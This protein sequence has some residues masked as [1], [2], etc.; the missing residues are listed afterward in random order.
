MREFQITLRKFH[1]HLQKRR[2]KDHSLELKDPS[3]YTF[4]DVLEITTRLHE[5]H[6]NAGEVKNCMGL[7][8]RMFRHA[9]EKSST[10]E[11]LLSFVPSD[12]YGSVICGGFTMILT[13]CQPF[14]TS[15]PKL[16][17]CPWG[18]YKER[19]NATAKFQIT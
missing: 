5:E 13:V 6:K 18:I 3:E 2:D 11:N 12:T 19:K 10:L 7:I 9:G 4:K 14:L 1:E 17:L 8:R 16:N 15:H